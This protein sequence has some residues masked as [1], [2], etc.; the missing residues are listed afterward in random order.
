MKLFKISQKKKKF[1]YYNQSSFYDSAIV[2][3]ENEYQAKRIHPC[4]IYTWDDSNESWIERDEQVN[5]ES[6]AI[7]FWVK[8]IKK[9]K[10]E[11]IG[12]ADISVKE[13][14]VLASY[15]AG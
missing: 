11:Y 10:V 7:R 13:G 15:N 2:C 12:E 5:I 14:V 6:M 9:I 3:A 4:N 1:Y 8:H